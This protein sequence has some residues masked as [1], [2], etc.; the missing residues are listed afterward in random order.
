[1]REREHR[2]KRLPPGAVST[3]TSWR[4]REKTTDAEV[5]RLIGDRQRYFTLIGNVAYKR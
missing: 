4:R 2:K 1:M 5:S 3:R